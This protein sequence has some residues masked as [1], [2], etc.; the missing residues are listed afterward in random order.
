MCGR[1]APGAGVWEEADS[2]LRVC[3]PRLPAPPPGLRGALAPGL[4]PRVAG[5]DSVFLLSGR[6]EALR[7]KPPS[8]GPTPRSS[9]RTAFPPR[10]PRGAGP[11][12]ATAGPAP[13]GGLEPFQDGTGF[14]LLDFEMTIYHYN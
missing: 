2:A 13:G 3:A 11:T 1:Q 8:P 5:S 9:G 6:W 14:S 7:P 4:C 10:D 12:R